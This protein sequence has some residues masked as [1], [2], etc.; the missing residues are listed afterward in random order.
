MIYVLICD[1][2]SYISD[3]TGWAKKVS[4]IIFLITLFTASQF[5]NFWH[6]YSIRNLQRKD[7]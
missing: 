6:M 1:V 5:R 2:A 7:V 3:Y 4:L